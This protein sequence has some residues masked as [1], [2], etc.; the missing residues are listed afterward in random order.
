MPSNFHDK[1]V[2]TFCISGSSLSKNHLTLVR[3]E[4]DGVFYYNYKI[5]KG[6]NIILVSKTDKEVPKSIDLLLLKSQ[7][8]D[9][10]IDYRT[11]SID[12]ISSIE[13]SS[14]LFIELLHTIHKPLLVSSLSQE[15]E[16]AFRVVYGEN[17]GTTS[18]R[19]ILINDLGSLIKLKG[20]QTLGVEFLK[21]SQQKMLD[22]Y[23]LMKDESEAEGILCALESQLREVIPSTYL[24]RPNV[25][26]VIRKARAN[27]IKRVIGL[28]HEHLLPLAQCEG[29]IIY[30]NTFALIR[31]LSLANLKGGIVVLE[32]NDHVAGL[33]K[34]LGAKSNDLSAM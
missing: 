32:G 21:S 2:G 8:D 24:E 29:R 18:T 12:M 7:L 14:V 9:N 30:Q 20:V 25:I 11:R 19:R 1:R 26:D 27:G 34:S 6:Y 33:A 13:K 17:H 16:E 23:I 5:D 22:N 15:T 28:D 31:L 10:D 3:K 4:V